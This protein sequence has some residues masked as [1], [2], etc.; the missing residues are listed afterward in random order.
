M[1]RMAPVSQNG[2][3][4]RGRTVMILVALLG[5]VAGCTRAGPPRQTPAS[6]PPSTPPAAAVVDARGQLAVRVAAAED[7]RYVAAYQLY[8]GG[9][10][11]RTVTVV[12]ATDGSWQ[13]DLPGGAMSGRADIAVTRNA[14]GLYQCRL[15]HA[16]SCV[17]VAGPDG[18][19]PADIDPRVQHIFTDWMDTL[20]DTSA[21]L[22]VAATSRL[23]GSRG[24]C[25][26][27]DSNTASL[28][29]PIDPGVYCYD[30][31]GMLTA[32][33]VGFGTLLLSTGPAPAP[34]TAMLPGP[35]VAADPL[36]LVAPPPPSQSASPSGTG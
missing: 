23:H 20:T 1:I 35:V 22:S 24:D 12:V 16:A 7:R 6:T 19:L 28:R 30:R 3:V 21:A 36:P 13:V 14:D 9:G 33:R 5:A 8:D 17:R 25:F 27:V 4:L 31:T 34:P 26:A 2:A 29:P 15:G 32:A 18:S 11:A 10:R